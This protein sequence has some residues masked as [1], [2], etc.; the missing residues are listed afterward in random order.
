[1]WVSLFGVC[2]EV[3]GGGE[4]TP[5]LSKTCQNYARNFKFGT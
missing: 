4:I 5:A 3:G 1:M 2:F